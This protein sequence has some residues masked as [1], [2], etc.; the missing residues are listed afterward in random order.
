MNTLTTITCLSALFS[1]SILGQTAPRTASR[2]AG[3]DLSPL[4]QEVQRFD[5]ANGSLIDG[6]AELSQDRSVQLHLG[7]E[8]MLRGRLQSPRDRSAKFS[9]HLEHRT[10]RDILNAL[11][12]SDPRYLW[13]MDGSSINVYP[14]S[15]A[16]DKTDLLNFPVERIELSGIPDPD[17]ALTPLSKLFPN[18]QVGYMQIGGSNEYDAPWTVTFEHLTVRQLMNRITEHIGPRAMW[19]WQGGKDGRLFT[20][21]RGGFHTDQSQ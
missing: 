10:V 19:S 4:D 1:A 7:I 20:F 3:A 8:E 21:L 14:R 5:L 11:C 9:L 17:E 15:R 12:D 16:E 13:S 6:L 2:A 18:E